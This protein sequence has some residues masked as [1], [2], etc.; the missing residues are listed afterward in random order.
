MM[1]IEINGYLIYIQNYYFYFLL[2]KGFPY[3]IELIK[4][5]K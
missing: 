3:Q 1:K 5:N 4:L 2:Q